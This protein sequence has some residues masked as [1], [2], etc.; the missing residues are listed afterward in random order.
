M[1]N[2]DEFLLFSHEKAKIISE[3]QIGKSACGQTAIINLL[4]ALKFNKIP[5][6]EEILLNFSP[7][8]RNYNTKSLLEYLESRVKAG[9]IHTDLI[10]IINKITESKIQSKFFVFNYRN[11]PSKFSK[12]ILKYMQ[13]DC[14]PLLTENLFLA[15]NDAWHHQMVYG[16]NEKSIFLTNP[17][18]IT[19]INKAFNWIS[20]NSWM[21]IP[22]DHITQRRFFLEKEEEILQSTPW[23]EFNVYDQ[24]VNIYSKKYEVK[25][26]K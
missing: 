9:T 2:K 7:R 22:E 18:D 5:S 19:D 8:L 4:K 24:I 21:V 23:K 16:V 11:N 10:E 20:S 14:V 1:I 12:W 17:L 3:N 15:G 25:L 26:R 13:R 6:N